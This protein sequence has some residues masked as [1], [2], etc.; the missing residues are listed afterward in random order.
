MNVILDPLLTALESNNWTALFVI[1]AFAL[2]L[3][4]KSISEFFENRANKHQR[5]IAEALK[6]EAISGASREFLHEELNYFIFKKITGISAD[7]TLREKLRDVIARSQGELQIRQLS[8]ASQFIQMKGGRLK[9]VVT[10]ADRFFALLNIV[11]GAFISFAGLALFML[12]GL[13]KTTSLIQIVTAMC[14]GLVF[15]AF[16]LF[17]ISEAF[18]A[19]AAIRI[20]PIITRLEPPPIDA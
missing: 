16:A 8:R 14:F 6:L 13:A 5:F 10:R 19:F 15:F 1:V 17:L 2:I 7:A 9:I 3:N 12:P 18:P 4:L 11:F 20:S